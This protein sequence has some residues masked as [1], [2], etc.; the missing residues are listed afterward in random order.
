MI[1]R[2]LEVTWGS[3][4]LSYLKSSAI[5]TQFAFSLAVTLI[6]LFLMVSLSL[7]IPL[8]FFVLLSAGHFTLFSILNIITTYYTSKQLNE[9][10]KAANRQ[11]EA[12]QRLQEMDP[13]SNKRCGYTEGNA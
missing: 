7:S 11:L 2:D 8:Q 1:K 4:I 5:V 13:D 6:G 10:Y 3:I 9:I 12:I